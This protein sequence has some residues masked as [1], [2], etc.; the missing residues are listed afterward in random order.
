MR[1]DR[2]TVV[3]IT[4][5]SRGIGRA[6]A[7]EFARKGAKLVLLAR[8]AGRLDEVARKV[9][10]AGGE[11]LPLV[12]D[13]SREADCRAW[14]GEA[15][16]RFGRIDVLVNNAGFGHYADAAGLTTEALERIFK[17]NLYGT[18]WCTQAVL[19]HMK[20]RRSGHIV[21]VSSVIS[22]R[23]IPFMTAYCMTKFAM[24][25]FTEGLL[26]ELLPFRIGVSL[27][28]PGLT[29]TDFQSNTTKK[30]FEPLMKN[31]T[32]MSPEKVGK[33]I[34]RAVRCNRKRTYLTTQ[35]RF[36]VWAQ[37]FSPGFVDWAI[38]RMYGRKLSQAPL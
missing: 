32:G 4:G 9:R 23:S 24:N 3:A 28:C 19:P 27:L 2:D 15:L 13:V 14:V 36:L 37:K 10:D 35:G 18:I 7:V 22:I 5:A 16:A 8:D 26:V 29:A 1:I 33:A 12:C 11:A 34:V 31:E 38:C 20:E 6:A 25:A 30:D 21:N 17:T